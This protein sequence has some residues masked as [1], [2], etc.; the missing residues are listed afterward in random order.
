MAGRRGWVGQRTV[1]GGSATGEDGDEHEHANHQRDQRE[2]ALARMCERLVVGWLARM[3]SGVAVAIMREAA[4][5]ASARPAQPAEPVA[6]WGRQRGGGGAGGQGRYGRGCLGEPGSVGG[7]RSE[8]T[9]RYRLGGRGADPGRIGAHRGGAE[10]DGV[11]GVGV[12]GSRAS[13]FCGDQVSDHGNARG[14]ADEQHGVELGGIDLGRLQRPAQGG[15]GGADRRADH[16]FELAAGQPDLG[17]KLGEQYRN[18]GF[19]VRGQGFLGG[20]ALAAQP[21]GGA[22]GPGI[23]RVEAGDCAVESSVD[24]GEHGL[25]EV[26]PAESL[27]AF[28]ASEDREAVLGAAQNGRIESAPAEVIDRDQRARVEAI[29][30]SVVRGGGLG[31]GEHVDLAK[32]GQL[33]DLGEEFTLVGSPVRRVSQ[34]D[35]TGSATLTVADDVN[36]VP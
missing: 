15:D 35:H 4:R 5:A 9:Q 23:G 26:D 25:V 12:D 36:D 29:V 13:E 7:E 1:G 34:G 31:L 24:V 10:G 6:A 18:G 16:F 27:D 14:T 21:D 2:P 28:W 20:D 8:A 17:L 19:G 30:V 22:G 32:S 33:G 11:F 3:L